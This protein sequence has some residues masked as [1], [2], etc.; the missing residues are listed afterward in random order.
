LPIRS[1][2]VSL[3]GKLIAVTVG[4]L[5]IFIWVLV[6][7]SATVLQK[8]FGQ[9]LSDQQYAATRRL[10]AE[11][12]HKLKERRQALGKVASSAPTDLS[13]HAVET[14]L[15]S[16]PA[17]HTLFTAGITIIGLNGKV[18]A[19]YPVIKGRRGIF[20]G[21]RDY[22]QKVV[23]SGRPYVGM[24]VIGRASKRPVLTIGVP[25]FDGAG[26]LR[27]V[28]TGAT[29]L[30]APN[31]LGVIS[32]P[33]MTGGSDFYVF[34]PPDNIIVAATDAKRVM[35][36]PPVR[37]IN[38]MYDRFV[39]GF[40]GSGIAVSSEGIKK[41]ISGQ[42]LS[43]ARWIV[44][45]ALP[46]AI[47]FGPVKAMQDYLVIVAAILTLLASFITFW[48]AR[49]MLR[50]LEAARTTMRQMTK[51]DLPL[52]PLSVQRHDEVGQMIADFNQLIEGRQRI[53]QEL[54]K[55]E[56]EFRALVENSPDIVARYDREFRCVYANPAIQAAIG[57]PNHEV[58]GK[59]TEQMGLAQ[60]FVSTWNASIKKVILTRQSVT[61][62]FSFPTT[63]GVR[64][65]QARMVPEFG[66][67]GEVMNVLTVARDIS[68]IKGGEAVLRES[69]QRIHGITANT[70]GMVFQCQLRTQDGALLFTYVSEG[71][72]Q[73][74][75]LTPGQIQSNRRT[76]PDCLAE[77]DRAS[78]HESLRNSALTME[79]WNWEGRTLAI[80]GEQKWINCRATPRFSSE[81]DII[82]EGVMLNVTDGKRSEEEIRQSRQ[83]LRELSAHMEHVREEERKRIAREVHDELGQALTVLR[84]DVSLLRLNFGGQSPQLLERIQSMKEVV[85]RTIQIVRHVTSTLRPVA[86]DLGLTAALEWLVEEFNSHAGITCQ[87]KSVGCDEVVLDDN[88]ATA[89]FRIV[90]ESLT[91]VAKHAEA[92]EV[93]ILIELD[94]QENL[95]V[96]ICDNGKG[97]IT[98]AARK[99]GSF[100][101]IG[102]HERTLMLGGTLAI[103]SAPGQ[104]TQV[105]VCIPAA[106][107]LNAA[108]Q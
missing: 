92:S 21:D 89:L 28:M 5:V 71:S 25:V 12:D 39:D 102:M 59:T 6:F 8:Q 46:T 83:L 15:G 56:E 68:V 106:M 74:L 10:A 86:L 31:F 70:P 107:Q 81:G 3:K 60:N 77:T 63:A 101:L 23:A 62:E 85:D 44:I 90:Q 72:K 41:L 64:H 42:H 45:A 79:V 65:F 84:M 99:N 66:A 30:T 95:C 103:H 93:E 105:E 69:E 2:F 33:N 50:P 108:R 52:A 48:V 24:P 27:A 82:W 76:I 18:I 37:G 51:G 38:A 1:Y 80:N 29:D 17:L 67:G 16:L 97:F 35:T 73:L 40:N 43:E 4:L 54:K 58:I 9:I 53:E 32:D 61:F 78:F 7:F 87:L 49:R 55:R 96:K 94:G 34:S 13:P 36:A 75:G 14:Y 91:N 11:L 26:K 104:G 88:R 98:D 100:G 47:A 57:L 19:D 20:F 22:F